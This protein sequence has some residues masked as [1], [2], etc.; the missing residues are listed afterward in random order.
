MPQA[1]TENRCSSNAA[2]TG[3]E[4]VQQQCRRHQICATNLLRTG[5]ATKLQHLQKLENKCGN[6][7]AGT[8][9][10]IGKC[11]SVRAAHTAT[12]SGP[13]DSAAGRK[14]F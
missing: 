4:Q 10:K 1:P 11:C 8:N 2:G 13:A 7:I 5:S 6:F 14:G 3:R 12:E 9:G